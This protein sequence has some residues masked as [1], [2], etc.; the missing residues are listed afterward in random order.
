MINQNQNGKTTIV[1]F[2][3]RRFCNRGIHRR[4]AF[5]GIHR[6]GVSEGVPQIH[7][8][9]SGACAKG[10]VD[11]GKHNSAARWKGATHNTKAEY[12]DERIA[13][14]NAIAAEIVTAQKNPT[15]DLNAA[16]PGRPEL[17]S[18]NVHFNSQ[19]ILIQAVQVSAEIDKLLP[20]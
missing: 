13:A 15:D 12:P 1:A 14:R 19:G 10:K 9:N 17:H 20:R 18:D 8:D 2:T 16:V 11:L 3:R 6:G 4:A 5:P 7:Q